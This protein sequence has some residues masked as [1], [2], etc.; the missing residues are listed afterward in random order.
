[1]VGGAVGQPPHLERPA[2]APG[3]AAGVAVAA[4]ARAVLPVAH[5]RRP[6]V[7]L[8]RDVVELGEP[9]GKRLGCAP[10]VGAA[11]DPIVS[12]T[13]RVQH[14][15]AGECGEDEREQLGYWC[16]KHRVEGLEETHKVDLAVLGGFDAR[17]SRQRLPC[18]RAAVGVHDTQVEVLHEH[19]RKRASAGGALSRAD[20]E[21]ALARA[22][23][24]RELTAQRGSRVEAGDRACRRQAARLV[25]PFLR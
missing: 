5:A 19:P 14:A 2:V 6:R 17:Y 4:A 7:W 21:P 9:R 25:V 16:V 13:H 23:A 18:Q 8:W 24:H 11:R 12:V 3:T 20:D 1:M 22:A 15:R 10:E